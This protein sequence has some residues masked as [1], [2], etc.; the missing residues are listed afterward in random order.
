MR[1]NV[2]PPVNKQCNTCNR[3]YNVIYDKP[4]SPHIEGMDVYPT[5]IGLYHPVLILCKKAKGGKQND[6][7]Q[8]GR[9]N[10]NIVRLGNRLSNLV[11][12]S[13]K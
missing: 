11:R 6:I 3:K 4:H 2:Y 1:F 5:E 13:T 8:S 9:I 7:Y 10:A 12:I